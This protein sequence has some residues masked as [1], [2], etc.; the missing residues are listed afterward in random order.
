MAAYNNAAKTFIDALYAEVRRIVVEH[1]PTAGVL[2]VKGEYDT[3]G[4]IVRAQRVTDTAGVDIAGWDD[5]GDNIE[6]D[7]EEHLYTPFDSLADDIDC[8]LLQWIGDLTGDDLLG[9]DSEINIVEGGSDAH[10][11]D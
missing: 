1:Y 8:A 10:L 5:N 4:F 6:P 9:D 11:G 3:D 2:H 7:V